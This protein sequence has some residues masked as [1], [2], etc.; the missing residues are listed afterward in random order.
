MEDDEIQIVGGIKVYRGDFQ[1]TP[2]LVRA[3]RAQAKKIEKL[4]S[5]VFP[6]VPTELLRGAVFNGL[7]VFILL[8][9]G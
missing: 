7:Y 1:G 4:K 9:L 6:E 2:T 8:Q 5:G 3:P